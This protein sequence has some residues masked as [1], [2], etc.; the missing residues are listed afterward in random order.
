MTYAI[1]EF[2]HDEPYKVREDEQFDDLHEAAV[3]LKRAIWWDRY[4]LN[5]RLVRFD[6]RTGETE[7]LRD[8]EEDD[9]LHWERSEEL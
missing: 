6:D 1:A 8:S 3:A 4:D 9:L 2:E 7:P 5:L